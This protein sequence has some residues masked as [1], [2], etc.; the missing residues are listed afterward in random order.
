MDRATAEH[1]LRS[2][3]PVTWRGKMDYECMTGT[4]TAII[5]RHIGGRDLTSVE[6]VNPVSGN[7]NTVRIEEVEY[8]QPQYIHGGAGDES[9]NTARI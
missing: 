1:A 4:L 2:G 8:W 9:N 7:S 3:R 6:I 5:M